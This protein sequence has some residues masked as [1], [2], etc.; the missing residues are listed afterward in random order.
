MDKY[1]ESWLTGLSESTK[2]NYLKDWSKWLDFIG[3]T[4]PHPCLALRS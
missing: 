2:K 4:P 1:V 3:T